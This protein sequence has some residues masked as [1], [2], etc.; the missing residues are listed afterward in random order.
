MPLAL[1]PNPGL[2]HTHTHTHA[3]THRHARTRLPC[4][5]SQSLSRTG[6]AP[7]LSFGIM[8][9]SAHLPSAQLLDCLCSEDTAGECWVSE[10]VRVVNDLDVYW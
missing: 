10:G 4:F 7:L 5:V 3:H 2:T 8:Q 1:S 6:S 9:G